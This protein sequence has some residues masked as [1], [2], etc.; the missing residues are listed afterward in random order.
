[1]AKKPTAKRVSILGAATAVLA[2]VIVVIAAAAGAISPGEGVGVD[3]LKGFLSPAQSALSSVGEEAIQGAKDAAGGESEE[4][5]DSGEEAGGAVTVT[6][7]HVS[8]GDTF[9]VK[10]ASGKEYKVRLIGVDTPES[11]SPDERKN[12]PFGKTASDFTKKM[13]LGK[14]IT[15]TFDTQST[16]KYGRVLAYAFLPDGTFYNDLL[17]KEGYARVMTV[18]PNVAHENDFAAA[19]DYA[20]SLGLGVWENYESIFPEG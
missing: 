19:A 8:D 11:V 15:L 12:V 14:K 20:K 18:P 17:V 1:M 13:L 10:D 4:T 6:V 5:G 3:S 9:T 2:A 16:D 7:E